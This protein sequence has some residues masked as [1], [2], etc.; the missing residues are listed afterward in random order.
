[1]IIKQTDRIITNVNSAGLLCKLVFCKSLHTAC[2]IYVEQYNKRFRWVLKVS[3]T[4]QFQQ[5][6]A[7]LSWSTM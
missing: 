1:M 4:E 7:V 3:D 5:Y 6:Y 2:D